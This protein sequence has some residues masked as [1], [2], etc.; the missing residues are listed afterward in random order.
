[1][2]RNTM[3]DSESSQSPAS[4][5]SGDASSSHDVITRTLRHTEIIAA[6]LLSIATVATAWSAYQ[7]SRW[8]GVQALSF[9]EASTIRSESN[10]EFNLAIQLQIIDT[11]LVTQWTIAHHE[12]DHELIDFYESSLIRPALL[13]HLDEWTPSATEQDALSTAHPLA[14]D[15][16]MEELLADSDRLEAESTSRTQEAKVANQTSDNYVLSTVIF[17]SVMFFAGIA[18][19]FSSRRIRG[20]LVFI[21]FLMLVTGGL[22]IGNLPVQ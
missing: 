8:S 6:I 9:A 15:A 21:G 4:D 14:S 1:M 18:S 22:W 19:K 11:E 13:D 5:T 2:E 16:Y 12:G 3:K 7:S 10:R 17:A 20:G